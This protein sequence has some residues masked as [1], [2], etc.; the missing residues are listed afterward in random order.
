MKATIAITDDHDVV[1]NEIA[2]LLERFNYKVVIKAENGLDLINQ[3]SCSR[4]LP[5][6][7]IMDVRMPRLNGI[8]TTRQLTRLWPSIGVIGFSTYDDEVTRQAMLDAGAKAYLVK[9]TSIEEMC[10]CIDAVANLKKE[11]KSARVE[12]PVTS[13]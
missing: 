10:D 5:D 1:R 12:I 8:E 4:T 7:C 11:T 6:V 3:L 9:N 13:P 2:G